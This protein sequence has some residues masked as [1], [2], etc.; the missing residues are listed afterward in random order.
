MFDAIGSL[1]V[2]IDDED[3]AIRGHDGEAIVFAGGYDQ[4]FVKYEREAGVLIVELLNSAPAMI[5]E[6]RAVRPEAESLRR[7]NSRLR[8]AIW[9]LEDRGEDDER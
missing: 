5:A 7:E 3:G 9:E 6:V 2:V 8:E 4:P 1:P